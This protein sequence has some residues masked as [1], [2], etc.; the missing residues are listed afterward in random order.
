MQRAGWL[1]RAKEGV[2]TRELSDV[3]S[4]MSWWVSS[5]KPWCDRLGSATMAM[6]LQGWTSLRT[7]ERGAKGNLCYALGQQKGENREGWCRRGYS[8]IVHPSNS[9]RRPIREYVGLKGPHMAD[10]GHAK[11]GKEWLTSWEMMG[12]QDVGEKN[13]VTAFSELPQLD[14]LQPTTTRDFGGGDGDV[15]RGWW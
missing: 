4:T 12:L 11:A 1:A 8:L 7:R 5:M 14:M 6:G 9:R 13:A 2:E 3:I 10:G 15:E